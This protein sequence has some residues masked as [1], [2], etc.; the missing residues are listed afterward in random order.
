M[1]YHYT[2][3]ATLLTLLVYLVVSLNVARARG[4]YG[5]K[6]PAVTGNEYFERAYRVQMNTLEQMVFFLPSMW[7]YAILSTDK[8][9][10]VGGLIWVVGRVIYSVSY[11]RNPASRGVGFTISFIAAIGL[12]L[13]AAYGVL[14]ALM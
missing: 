8:V 1:S 3:A 12:F 5:V 14:K 10:A 2:Q 13:G 6:A 9:A 4:K 11:I 7:L